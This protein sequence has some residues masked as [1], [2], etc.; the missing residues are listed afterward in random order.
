MQTDKIIKFINETHQEVLTDIY[1]N[2]Q[3]IFFCIFISTLSLFNI[4]RL[5]SKIN[6]LTREIEKQGGK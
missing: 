2:E 5:N 4:Y 3:M 6:K 1:W